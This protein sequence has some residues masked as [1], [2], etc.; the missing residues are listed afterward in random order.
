MAGRCWLVVTV[1]EAAK[2]LT[3]SVMAVV[4]LSLILAGCGSGGGSGTS[5]G[6][7]D[8][9]PPTTETPPTTGMPP[10]T[11]TPPTTRTPPTERTPPTN[12]GPGPVVQQ[13]VHVVDG[14]TIEIDGQRYRLQGFDAPERHQMCRG[15]DDA[16]WAC[17]QAAT[18]TLER[19][20]STGTVGCEDS[21]QRS[22]GRIVGSCSAGGAEFGAALVRAGLA[23]NEPR[24]APDYSAREREARNRGAGMHAGR[25][26][27]PW[28]WRAGDRLGDAVPGHLL[29]RDADIEVRGVLPPEQRPGEVVQYDPAD[30]MDATA[31]GGWTNRS[32][33]AV[34]HD[35]G[36]V[37]G[38]SWTPHFPGTNPKEADGRASWS[39]L[40]AGVDTGDGGAMSGRVLITLADFSDPEV[41]VYFTG[42]RMIASGTPVRGMA[43]ENLH[44]SQGS[45]SSV[46]P[47]SQIKG[48]FHGDRH[49]EA[50]GVFEHGAM[51]GAFGAVRD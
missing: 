1:T 10:T 42:V 24:Y 25:Y 21:G 17:G 40:M 39:G 31:W 35:G 49:Q 26:L 30:L 4:A 44:V 15:A 29:S 48:R 19:L 28:D 45:F 41:D 38:L 27:A 9:A 20:V 12:P 18:A 6:G 22:Y 33:F 50:G 46:V 13:T 34:V 32:A 23:I 5:H 8:Q 3:K 7:N 51:V 11:E 47:G 37:L 43:W 14:D 16:P 36:D 2:T